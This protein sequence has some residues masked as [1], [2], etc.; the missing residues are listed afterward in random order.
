MAP[1]KEDTV[2]PPGDC[3]ASLVIIACTTDRVKK[4]QKFPQSWAAE[5]NEASK[6][7]IT[8]GSALPIP[9]GLTYLKFLVD[10]MRS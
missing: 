8:L 3:K 7:F 9:T 1:S 6:T 2:V 5:K 4:F 10:T